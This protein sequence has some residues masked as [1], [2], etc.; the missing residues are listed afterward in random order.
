MNILMNL[1]ILIALLVPF[2][3]LS[4]P[5]AASAAEMKYREPKVEYSA[6]SYVEAEGSRAPVLSKVYHAPGK[7][8]MEMQGMIMITRQDKSV[9][10]QLMPESKTYMEN[11]VDEPGA[12]GHAKTDMTRYKFDYTVIGDET[13]EGVRATKGRV[14]FSTPEGLTYKGFMW[15]TKDNILVR[16]DAAAT[17]DG[18]T[19]RF[20]TW[21]RNLKIGRLDPGLFEIPA[22]YSRMSMP[23][24]GGGAGFEEDYMKAIEKEQAE[25]R[26]EEERKKKEEEES[27][28][29]YT[30]EPR[31]TGRSYTAE[32]RAKGKKEPAT[33]GLEETLDPIKKLK[34]LFGR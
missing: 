13:V 17:A 4:A 11:P 29:S 6:D 20:K 14:T 26:K 5:P 10:W 24:G 1:L 27:G 9:A 33:K 8:R 18:R 19:V 21:L 12:S 31:D 28:R 7:E 32:P 34:G 25:G 15:L 16:M 23:G 22:G 30:S 2:G 3:P